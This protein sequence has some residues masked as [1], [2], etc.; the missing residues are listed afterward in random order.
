ML[1]WFEK[2]IEGFKGDNLKQ[3]ADN[4]YKILKQSDFYNRICSDPVLPICPLF[5]HSKITS[6]IAVC[7]ALQKAT[8]SDLK[9]KCLKEYKISDN[10]SAEY[11]D[12]DFIA[13]IRLAALFHDIGK[14]RSYTVQKKDLHFENYL[15]QTEEIINHI[16]QTVSVEILSKYELNKILPKLA[17]KNPTLDS[18]TILGDIIEDADSIASAADRIYELKVSSENNSLYIESRDKIFPHEI[19]FNEG[20]YRSNDGLN[21]AIIGY[22]GKLPITHEINSKD[23]TQIY[24]KD[25]V[26]DGKVI[27]NYASWGQ[28]SGDIGIFALDIMRIQEYVTEADELPMLRGG[29]AIVEETLKKAPIGAI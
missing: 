26:I 7:L 2:L 15:T 24:F 8:I 9:S 4:I 12:K 21:T 1:T 20:S 16:L 22:Q 29:S 27:Q 23:N 3:I 13:L 14:L 19:N 28:I 6:G 10:I 25:S 11:S 5:Y 18:K 17:T